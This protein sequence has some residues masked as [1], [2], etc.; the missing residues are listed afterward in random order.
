MSDPK[1]AVV[2]PAPAP[3]KTSMRGADTPLQYQAEKKSYMHYNVLAGVLVSLGVVFMFFPGSM[4]EADQTDHESQKVHM[5]VSEAVLIILTGLVCCS[6]FFEGV[7]EFLEEHLNETFLPV[8]NALNTELMGMGFLAVI[9]YFVLK[10]KALVWVGKQT[11]CLSDPRYMDN[12]VPVT[13]FHCDVKLIHMFEDIHMS[14]FL[15]LCLFFLR[16]VLLLYQVNIISA[17]WDKMEEKVNDPKIGEDGVVKEYREVWSKKTSSPREKKVAQET[18]EFM[19]FRK[20]FMEAGNASGED[21]DLDADFSFS[22]YLSIC[23]S[24]IATEVVEIPPVEWMALEIFFFFIWLALQMPPYLRLRFMFAYVCL[25]MILLMQ[26]AGKVEWVLQMLVPPYPKAGKGDKKVLPDDKESK[27]TR[28]KYLDYTGG[29]ANCKNKQD[30]LFW[31]GNPELTLHILRFM[32][33]AMLIFL[34]ILI[35][36]IPFAWKMGAEHFVVVMIP[37][38]IVLLALIMVPHELMKDFSICV[39]VELL[40]NP[41]VIA[42]VCRIMRLKKSLRAIKLLR[43]LQSQSVVNHA[44]E[45]EVIVV[46]TAALSPE[47]QKK[48]FELQ[49]VFEIFDMDKSGNVD[50]HELGGL[51]QALGISL[52]EDEKKNMMKEFD[53]DNSGSISFD[54]FWTYMKRRG[55]DVDAGELVKDVFKMMDQDGSGSVTTTEFIDVMEKLGTNLTKREIQD[56]VKEI[57]SG[58]DNEISLEEFAAVLEKYK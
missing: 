31:F 7:Q 22:E 54:E 38:P 33:L 12:G 24:H 10:F 41:K 44:A 47:D 55:E 46:D 28:P 11:I 48:Y 36:A 8:L 21:S 27:L 26:L 13:A 2:A 15:V 34:V 6:L 23:C 30:A 18:V 42:K 57:D 45:S 20:R 35:T 52:E 56:L 51:M 25:G 3:R 19:L 43:S 9:F 16:S 37:V 40:K 29:P 39:S 53:K 50:L 49:S 32:I 14:L 17:S 58:G 5:I 1:D 4:S